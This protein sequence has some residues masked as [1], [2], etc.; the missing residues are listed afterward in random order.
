VILGGHWTTPPHTL[1]DSSIELI[2]RKY[3]TLHP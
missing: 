2:I 1:V 3:L